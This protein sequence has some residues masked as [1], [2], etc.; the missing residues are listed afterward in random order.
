[1][2]R[3]KKLTILGTEYHIKYVDENADIL[4]GSE[5]R[6]DFWKKEILISDC[7]SWSRKQASKYRN[8]CLRHEL[9]HAFL[10]ESGLAYNSNSANHWA[11]NEE[12]V[13]WI[14]IQSPKIFTL[15]AEAGCL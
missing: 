2:R 3:K 10:Y 8:T 11:T 15:F 12:M 9:I 7:R 13:D 14:A 1:M 6:C 4:Y 5:G